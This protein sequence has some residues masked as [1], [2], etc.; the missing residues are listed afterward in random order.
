V[1]QK[2]VRLDDL[3][4]DAKREKTPEP[5]WKS[6]DEKLFARLE[7]ERTSQPSSHEQE[8]GGR[9]VWI[10]AALS[11][12]AAAA[13][14]LIVH[15]THDG[16][17]MA[18]ASTQS[19]GAVV[20]GNVEVGNHATKNLSSGDR[21]DVG[22]QVAYFDS[23]NASG[24]TAVRW[25]SQA[26]SVLQV[27]H[28]VSPLVLSLEKGIAEAQVTPVSSGE[29]FAIDVTS[30]SGE[31]V[32]V[33]VH[34]THL[35]V[36]REGDKVVVDLTEGV[37]SIGAPP[38]RGSTI[39]TLVTAPAHVELDARDLS[40]IR[41][42]HGAAAIRAAER[43]T[44][45]PA[46]ETAQIEAQNTA[47]ATN[48]GATDSIA[49]SI[50]VVRPPAQTQIVK[51]PVSFGAT[52]NVTVAPAMLT[53]QDELANAIASCGRN[54]VAPEITF[55]T[56]LVLNVNDD[57]SVQNARFQ[58]PLLPEARDCA[59]NVIYKRTKLETSG[60]IDVPIRITK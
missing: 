20:A 46:T 26:G 14:L 15:P 30:S 10:G 24:E 54:A 2:N 21:I 6:V 19:A 7:H 49:D 1:K 58:P 45:Q 35:R 43:V 50:A 29:A 5:D 39:G 11:L 47:L 37:V 23:K 12:A 57:G 41:V 52:T 32:R 22:D 4:R 60:H 42:D 28:A 44:P 48:A 13:A 16:V 40:T 8:R 17:D 25:S 36:A 53:T 27:E 3:I 31:V 38:R 33:A 55:T 34:G 9:V 18:R 59:A 56:T 51:P